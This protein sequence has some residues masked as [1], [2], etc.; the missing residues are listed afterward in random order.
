MVNDPTIPSKWKWSTLGEVCFPPQYGWTTSATPIGNV[1]LLRTT[2]ITSGKINWTTVP[3]CSQEPPNIEKYI[4][5][6][7]DIVISRAGSVGYSYLIRNPEQAIFAS[8]LIRFRPKINPQYVSYFLQSPLYWEAISESSIGIAVPN[9]NASKLKQIKIPIP[10]LHDQERIVAKIEEL[11]TQLD[12]G[13]AA[14][15]RVQ[16]GLKRYKASVL[17]AAVEGRL[18]P[19]DPS[20]EPAEEMLRRLGKKPLEGEDLPTLPQG[21]CWTKVGDVGKVKGGKRLPAGHNYSVT[22]TM[23]PYIRVVD[24]NELSILT[25]DIKYLEPE[26]HQIIKKYIIKKEDVFISIAGSIG[27]VGVIP[28]NLDGANLTEN[29]ARITDLHALQNRYLAFFLSSPLGRKQISESTIST[30]QPKLAL[31]RIEKI[32][33]PLPPLNEQK[34]IKEDI[35]LRFSLVNEIE[36]V[37]STTLARATSLRQAVL[38]QAFEGK[39]TD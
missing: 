2:D 29:A 18:V 31:F 38:K 35:E 25:D 10:P 30:N 11:F 12:A 34:R 39:L 33:I 36:S 27:K 15:K 8:Y 14:L 9:V 24:F 13:T 21:W 19:Q 22:P 37:V 26:T 20:D 16:A 6:D 7:G 1:R 5:Q 23:H 3:F 28:N 17:K 4:L 32:H